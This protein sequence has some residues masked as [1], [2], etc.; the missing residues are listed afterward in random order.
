MDRR[1][2]V[3]LSASI[4]FIL[5]TLGLLSAPAPEAS[6]RPSF[7]HSITTCELCHHADSYRPCT[8]CHEPAVAQATCT[9][10]HSKL[11]T[12]GGS[13][14]WQ[15]HVP[16]TGAPSADDSGCPTCH[17][18]EPHLGSSPSCTSCHQMGAASP[19]HDAIDQQKPEKC[20]D[21]HTTKLSHGTRDC[22]TC[23]ATS[24]HPNVPATPAVCNQCHPANVFNGNGD[25]LACHSASG[26]F[27]GFT[28]NDIHDATLP[29]APISGRSCSSCHPG[30]ERHGPKGVGCVECHTRAPAFHHGTAP[31]TGVKSCQ[32]C[33]GNKAQ[34]GSGTTCTT[35]HKG[36]Q[37]LADP[38]SVSPSAGCTTCH[39][40]SVKGTKDCLKCH[41][42]PIY[43]V[44]PSVGSCASCHGSGRASHAGV[45]RCRTCHSNIDR[46]HHITR[47]VRPSCNTKGCH[48]NYEPHRP[49][50]KCASCHG[51][52]AVHDST[53][54]N[55]PADTWSVCGSC[56]TFVK[57]ALAAGVPACSQCHDTTQHDADYRLPECTSCHDKVKH[58]EKV[59]C[60]L[61]HSDLEKAHHRVGSVRTRA[62]SDCHTGAAIH[63]SGT[64]G[65]AAFTCGTCH[66]GSVHGV[67]SRPEPSICI[68][69]HENGPDHA[70]DLACKQCHW[71]AAH[72]AKPDA[73][74]FGSYTPMSLDLPTL[75]QKSGNEGVKTPTRGSFAGTGF[76][77]FGA[78]AVAVLLIGAGFLL[79]RR[80]L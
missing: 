21:C 72:A 77:M 24:P 1:R 43:H 74:V 57:A 8:D 18:T 50:V 44:T 3:L 67:L 45:V 35:C 6:A 5:A 13:T 61:C 62:C 75:P 19:H 73:A 14:C 29:D 17:G 12:S 58:A 39:D 54:R 49:G 34:H 20:T 53:P 68:T 22:T 10:C 9:T 7:M 40:S 15:C 52:K 28:D 76:E 63:A 26:G 69:C 4:I 64:P 48:V 70:G 79:R 51:R 42:P 33:H 65:G 38:L 60:R 11:T 30:K 46:G 59:D 2:L 31:D 37:H 16:S 55:L 36:A 27:A 32:D 66:E 71:P 78:L 47:V 80:R 41:R 56:H 23:H 25:C